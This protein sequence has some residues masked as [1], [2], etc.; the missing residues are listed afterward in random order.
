MPRRSFSGLILETVMELKAD[1]AEIK[2]RI[3]NGM[4]QK[5]EALGDFG[6]QF[7]D[8]AHHGLAHYD[9]GHPPRV[10]FLLTACFVIGLNAQPGEHRLHCPL[11]IEKVGLALLSE[12]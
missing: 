7:P 2:T 3:F 1:V 6:V 4:G 5:V 10:E 12:P 11:R 9:S 8:E